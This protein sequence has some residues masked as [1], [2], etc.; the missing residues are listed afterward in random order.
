RHQRDA[1][2]VP[3]GIAQHAPAVALLLEVSLRRAHRA[4]VL[5]LS[6]GLLDALD[7]EIEVEPVL[8]GLLLRHR[9]ERDPRRP[10][11]RAREDH[12]A[13]AEALLDLDAQHAAPELREPLGVPRVDRDEADLSQRAR[14]HQ[15]FISS[16]AASP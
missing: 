14:G 7:L 15:A 12:V 10:L 2:L 16:S 5:E 3:L 4:Q 1:E 11:V 9:L 6:G 8:A 13:V